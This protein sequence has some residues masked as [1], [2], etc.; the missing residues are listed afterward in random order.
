MNA[1][2]TDWGVSHLFTMEI[3]RNL[4]EFSSTLA[5]TAPELKFDE[6]GLD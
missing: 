3:D 4:D 6:Q 1:Y 2:I 5:F